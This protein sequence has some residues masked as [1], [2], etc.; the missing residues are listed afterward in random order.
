MTELAQIAHN[1]INRL[2]RTGTIIRPA[3][4]SH[5]GKYCVP[6]GHHP[7]YN[8]PS[9]VI[10]LCKSCHNKQHPYRERTLGQIKTLTIRSADIIKNIDELAIIHKDPDEAP[11]P[12]KMCRKL[13]RESANAWLNFR[14][15]Y[16]QLMSNI[17]QI[18]KQ[19][20]KK[21]A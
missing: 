13:L 7:D 18:E 3:Q 6:D 8:E 17:A 20:K 21:T 9:L 1:T 14:E 5:C 16:E 11:N 10:W 19:S 4:C 12:H 15:L 2:I